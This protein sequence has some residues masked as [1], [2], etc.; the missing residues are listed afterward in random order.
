LEESKTA[1]GEAS[2]KIAEL[3]EVDGDVKTMKAGP[4]GAASFVFLAGNAIELLL[5]SGVP[6][7]VVDL[8]DLIKFVAV[9]DGKPMFIGYH[10]DKRELAT[11][12][13]GLVTAEIVSSFG[14]KRESQDS[15]YI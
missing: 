7:V 5:T 12:G 2:V 14:D 15:V 6:K 13:N 3:S 10:G 4:P 8:S 1:A 9:E 11:D